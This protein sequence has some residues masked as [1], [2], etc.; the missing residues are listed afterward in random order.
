MWALFDRTLEH[1]KTR[2]QFG[3]PI[4]GFQ[5]LQHRLARL[6]AD[7]LLTDACV[8]E[9][10]EALDAQLPDAAALVSA[11]KVRCVASSRLVCTEGIQ[12]HGGMGVTDECDVGLYVKNLRVAEFILGDQYWHTDRWASL[13]GY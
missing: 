5:A 12:L 3:R 9:A 11:A 13:G 6:Y 1:T 7:L 2:V 10:A 8:R 4:A